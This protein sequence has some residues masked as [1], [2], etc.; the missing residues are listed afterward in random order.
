MAPS[1]LSIFLVALLT[2]A[3]TSLG[4]V[5]SLDIEQDLKSSI[6]E[7]KPSASGVP[8]RSLLSTGQ[9]SEND[10]NFMYETHIE[11]MEQQA[12][13]GFENMQQFP[14]PVEAP[15]L[16]AKSITTP[17]VY[18]LVEDNGRIMQVF[19]EPC[20]G[21][22]YVSK[23]VRI[24]NRVG[25]PLFDSPC[26]RYSFQYNNSRI[27]PEIV[28]HSNDVVT[29]LMFDLRNELLNHEIAWLVVSSL[30]RRPIQTQFDHSNCYYYY[31]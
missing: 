6:Q 8:T 23:S 15:V 5:D 17:P 31:Y 29:F 28:K 24:M 4:S 19:N 27:L 12:R 2:C 18:T 3:H 10:D 25:L 1:L 20:T 11:L 30:V 7:S 21:G 26:A 14:Q 22:G 16:I 13:T 9:Q